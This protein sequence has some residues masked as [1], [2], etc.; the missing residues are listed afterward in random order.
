V[1][2]STYAVAGVGVNDGP[3][4]GTAMGASTKT[5]RVA[6]FLLSWDRLGF[7]LL[8]FGSLALA[9]ILQGM[10]AGQPWR[11]LVLMELGGLLPWAFLAVPAARG[12]SSRPLTA[13]VLVYHSDRMS[14]RCAGA[15]KPRSAAH[16]RLQP[17]V[18]PLGP[19]SQTAA[20]TISAIL[21]SDSDLQCPPR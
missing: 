4:K 15:P 2:V 6:D 7:R 11:K 5:P 18:D 21:C 16:G 3:P 9:W 13:R 10:L 1:R 20:D 12:P 17:F 8:V 19:E 14:T